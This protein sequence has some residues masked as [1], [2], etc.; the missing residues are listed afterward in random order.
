MSRVA[1]VGHVEWV[2]FVGVRAFPAR[3]AVTPAERAFVH[4]GGGGVVAAVVLAELGAEV[5]FF[6]ALGRDANGKAAAAELAQRGVNVRAAWRDQ[7]TRSVITLL[8]AGGD[9]TII[10]IGERLE[11]VAADELEWARLKDADGVYFTA[12]DSA[13]A[14]KARSA[15]VLVATPRARGA[16]EHAQIPVDALVF[17]ASDE[18]ER[19][20]AQRLERQTRLMVETEGAAGGHWWGESEGRWPAAP[21][22]GEPKDD[23]G[24]G[25]SFAAGLTYG[26][27]RG[28]PVLD[29][30][31]IGAERGAV[32]LTRSGAP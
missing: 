3:G 27:A 12:G 26:L 21:L 1:V 11:P 10:T 23:Y 4:A 8:E 20:W 17:S 16:L 18:D 31:A 2:Q 6:C 28:L 19:H 13:A 15:H 29:A 32:A 7:P 9:R 30:A 5:D 22:P 25:D 24:C 14:T